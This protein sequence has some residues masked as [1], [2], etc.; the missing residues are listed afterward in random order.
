MVTGDGKGLMTGR[1]DTGPGMTSDP[2]P[3][4][5][6]ILEDDGAIRRSLMAKVE[7]TP[8]LALGLVAASLER[9]APLFD[10]PP[11][12]LLTDLV[13]PDGEAYDL[14]CRLRG[15][16]D[17]RIIVTSAPGDE[18]AV[19]S[20]LSAGAHSCVLKGATGLELK[21]AI[22]PV[23]SG[24]TPISPSIARYLIAQL[25]PRAGD[26]SE[27]EGEA[28]TPRE[29]EILRA[30]ALGGTCREVARDFGLSPCAVADHIQSVFRKLSVRTRAAAAARG[31]RSGVTGMD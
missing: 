2:S 24:E 13:L 14:I 5:V 23:V 27:P 19:V 9:A 8:G 18:R 10:G 22:F 30:L 25:K 1:R 6:A 7:A 4:T 15:E 31:I 20:A 16:T 26:A 12:V 28:L 17:T 21:E 3:Y 11:S 29:A